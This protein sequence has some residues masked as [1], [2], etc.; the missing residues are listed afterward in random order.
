[1]TEITERQRRLMGEAYSAGYHAGN[2]DAEQ[3]FKEWLE[4]NWEFLT[5]LAG[6]S[7]KEVSTDGQTKHERGG[8]AGE[9]A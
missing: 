3:G 5:I 6:E 8:S 2:C 1:M 7:D 4:D 9:S